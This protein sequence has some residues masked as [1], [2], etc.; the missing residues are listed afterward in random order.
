M[1]ENFSGEKSLFKMS[2]AALEHGNCDCLPRQNCVVVFSSCTT[3][4]FF[5][6]VT[7]SFRRRR[8]TTVGSPVRR[9]ALAPCPYRSGVEA[10]A[11]S[12]FHKLKAPCTIFSTTVSVS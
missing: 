2:F 12:K 1:P 5:L 4:Q 9:V 7:V 11:V 6:T 8:T 10:G 3:I